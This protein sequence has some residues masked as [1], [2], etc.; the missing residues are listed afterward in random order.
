M[1][2]K[3]L[4]AFAVV[5]LMAASSFGL[6]RQALQMRDDYGMDPLYDCA[7]QYYYYIPCPT[8]SWFWAFSGHDV[9]D[10]WGAWFQVGDMSTGGWGPCDPTDCHVLDEFRVLDFAGYGTTHMMFLI[11]FD[12][13]CA[14]DYGCPVG[15]SLWHSRT[16]GLGFGWNYINV[17]PPISICGCAVNPGPP[18]SGPRVLVTVTHIGSDGA[19]PAWGMDNISTAL[20]QAC[21]FHDL[22]C[23][24]AL[25]PRPYTGHYGT[26]HSGYYGNGGFDY[27]PPLWSMDGRDTTPDGSQYGFIEMCWRLYLTC[28][29]PTQV[30]PTSWGNIKSMYR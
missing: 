5:F 23:L 3:T 15:P 2:A 1:K 19:Y 21:A 20:E 6:Q 26:I 27:C 29:G 10:I 9:G 14:D 16:M 24:P 8:Y 11:E 13:Y 30:T 4:V 18:P 12:I 22:G 25:Y 28:T 17:D 7:L